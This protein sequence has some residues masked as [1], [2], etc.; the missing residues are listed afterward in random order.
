M[1]PSKRFG[2]TD[3]T[4]PLY[5][6]EQRRRRDL[7]PWTTIQGILA[8]LQF[9][10]FLV[11]F[12]LILRY[13]ASGEG[14]AAA[15]ASIVVKTLL[16]YAI[17]VTGSIWEKRVFGR[18]LFADAFFWEDVVSMAVLALHTA[19]LVGLLTGALDHRALMLLALAAYATYAVNA[20]QFL[21]K[22]RAARLEGGRSPAGLA[23]ASLGTVR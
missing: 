16:L 8:P 2:F 21:L 15:N 17:M 6:Q 12:C 23:D 10:A 7:S 14:L 4:G 20:A 19:Y 9:L 13:L 18:W 3:R 1:T 5:T 22:L 11:S